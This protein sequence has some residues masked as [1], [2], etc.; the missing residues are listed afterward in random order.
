MA[1]DFQF[2]AARVYREHVIG[3]LGFHVPATE[4]AAEFIALAKSLTAPSADSTPGW[5][6]DPPFPGAL[7]PPEKMVAGWRMI[8]A[9]RLFVDGV[10]SGVI[11]LTLLSGKKPSVFV[12]PPGTVI[13]KEYS[14]PAPR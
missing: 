8:C 10:E 11:F 9:S 4:T 1:T 12:S 5:R 6:T 13:P 14:R 7:E 3:Q 2:L